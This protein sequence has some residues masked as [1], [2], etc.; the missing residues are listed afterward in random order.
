MS[1]QHLGSSC[2]RAQVD[3]GSNH[4]TL[5]PLRTAILFHILL[6]RKELCLVRTRSPG[7]KVDS[8]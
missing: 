2:T 1:R 3:G 8:D 5:N 6:L 7:T 4:S